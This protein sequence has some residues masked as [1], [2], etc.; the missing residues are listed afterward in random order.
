MIPKHESKRDSLDVFT[1]VPH[2]HEYCKENTKSPRRR[3][4]ENCSLWALRVTEGGSSVS[5]WVWKELKKKD[6]IE[7]KVGRVCAAGLLLSR[8]GDI[9]EREMFRFNSGCG[10][11]SHP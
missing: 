9:S 5:L 10:W 4:A 1:F 8:P 2:T 6:N 11:R 3:L 7:G